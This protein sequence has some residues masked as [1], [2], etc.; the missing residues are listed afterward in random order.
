MVLT[1]P[2][3]MELEYALRFEFRAMNNEVEYE[4]VLAGISIP[5][6]WEQTAS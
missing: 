5:T 3:A 6:S 1:S 2:D 4:V